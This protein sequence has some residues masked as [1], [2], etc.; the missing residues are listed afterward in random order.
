MNKIVIIGTQP[1]CPRCKLL[2]EI[3]TQISETMGLRADIRHISYTSDEAAQYADSVGLVPG[4]AKDV[5]KK[6][7]IEINW[8]G[9]VEIPEEYNNQ[10]RKASRKYPMANRN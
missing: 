4:T 9:K 10:I 5:E 1:P 8:E 2:T 6:A 3:V 7:G